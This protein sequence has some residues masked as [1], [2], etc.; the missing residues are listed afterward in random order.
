MPAQKDVTT[1][2]TTFE[3]DLR[4]VLMDVRTAMT[5]LIGT[6][7]G[8]PR[9][10]HDISRVLDV[11]RNLAWKLTRVIRESDAFGAAG[12]IPGPNGI[13]ILLEAAERA[14]APQSAIEAVRAAAQR[15]QNLIAVHAG[16]RA[17]LQLLLSGQSSK[18]RRTAEILH[19]RAAF[20]ANSFILGIQARAYL[21]ADFVHPAAGHRFDVAS[22][23]SV[24]DLRRIRP[25]APYIIT[26]PRCSGADGVFHPA[27]T[28]PL[29]AERVKDGEVPLLHDFSSR[30]LPPFHRVD[31]GPSHVQHHLAPGPVGN[32]GAVTCVFGEVGRSVEALLRNPANP[33]AGIS[34]LIRVPCEVFIFDNLIHEDLCQ[35][36]QHEVALYSDICGHV[37]IEGPFHEAHRLPSDAEVEYLGC[38]PSVVLT[39]DVPRYPELAAYVFDRLDWPAERFRVF[40]VRIQYPFIPSSVYMRH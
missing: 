3:T 9:R 1:N 18:S 24:I 14:Q 22:V 21:R 5:E 35:S 26:Q 36:E 37:N 13:E 2:S 39:P 20:R 33:H 12:H 40:R 34:A 15:Y 16:D 29:D 17:S 8:R 6:L 32:S 28:Q 25:E 11:D 10:P 38:G 4:V 27:R 30:T 19:R 7:P 31:V 23:A